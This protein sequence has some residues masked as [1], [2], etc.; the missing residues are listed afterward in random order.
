MK[1]KSNVKANI[2]WNTSGT[3]FYCMAQWLI[4]I[5]V[6][7]LD[8]F[9][10]SGQLSLAMSTSSSFSA[11]T[12][13]SMRN[14]QISDV[15]ENYK[16]AHYIGSR[17]ITCV[18]SFALC[19]GYS[20]L[21]GFSN[22]QFWCI[23]F[24]MLIR[25]VEGVVDVLHGINQKY[26]RYDVIGKSFIARGIATISLFAT[27]LYV[28]HNMVI[29]LGIMALGNALIAIFWDI[30][31]TW[32][33]ERLES[34]IKDKKIIELLLACVPIAIFSFF[35]SME[36][37]IP[38]TQLQEIFGEEALGIYASIASP[39]LVVQVG[40]QVVFSPL[41]PMFI[42]VYNSGDYDKF[43]QMFHKVILMMVGTGIFISIAASIVGRWGLNLLF[44]EVILDY[45][46]LF[47]PIVWSTICMAFIWILQS[48]VI[49]MRCIISML[50]GMSVDFLVCLLS[51]KWFLQHF[52]WNGASIVQIVCLGML[53]MY[54]VVL[55]EIDIEKKKRKIRK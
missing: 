26:E 44:G 51:T 42:R 27:A 47:M 31:R 11:I 13:F 34:T 12:L 54:L 7:K 22:H 45:Y 48:I 24:F 1:E 29:T 16:T 30:R 32:K 20:L 50:I 28:T 39:T 46:Y 10:A 43:R 6:V 23:V 2:L 41:L 21:N 8:S 40:A 3:I 9:E 19:M 55:C 5:L 14:Y 4:T 35:L 17:V 25:I 53:A 38:K 52:S 33:L 37:L 15:E 36:N 18:L 49:G